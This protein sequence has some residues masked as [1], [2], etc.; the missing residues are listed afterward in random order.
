MNY[1]LLDDVVNKILLFVSHPC[2]DMIRDHFKQLA[3]YRE[4]EYN[5]LRAMV[6]EEQESD[7]EDDSEWDC[8]AH[9]GCCIE[10]WEDCQC[11][12]SNCGDE[13]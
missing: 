9:C 12:C 4:A 3:E 1:N 13:Y 7:E 2:A 11:W 6:D 5:V 10:L 8:D